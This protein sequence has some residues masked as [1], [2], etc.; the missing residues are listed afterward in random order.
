MCGI[1]G[2]V[3]KRP[4]GFYQGDATLFKNMLRINMIRG[5]DSTGVFGVGPKGNVDLVKGNSNGYVFTESSN[6]AEFEA[7]MRKKY[8]IVV[9][10]N[11]SATVGD[12]TPH[13]AHP[14][15]VGNI[16]LVHNGTLISTANL[17]KTTVDSE[18]IAHALNNHDMD[19]ALGKLHGAYALVWY[20]IAE[21]SLNIAR[22]VQRPLSILEYPDFWSIQSEAMMAAWLNGREQRKHSRIIDIEPEKVYSFTVGELG[23]DPQIQ[24]YKEYKPPYYGR[25]YPPEIPAQ[26][27]L[28]PPVTGGG[29]TRPIFGNSGSLSWRLGDTIRILFDDDKVTGNNRIFLGHPVIEDDIDTN[30]IVQYQLNNNDGGE[31]A[32]M[33]ELVNKGTF[34]MGKISATSIYHGRPILYVANV[35]PVFTIRALGGEEID[36]A[37]ID[38]V[39]ANGCPRCKGVVKREEIPETLIRQKVSGGVRVV[40]KSCLTESVKKAEEHRQAHVH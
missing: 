38:E 2:L 20:N 35:K 7:R 37:I 5:D 21:K 11:R 27:A 16:V 23:K 39:V 29:T 33:D 10:H 6:F 26:R 40:C 22:N 18:A 28:P 12:V 36:A 30:L 24:A 34:F 31:C 4:N 9:G 19:E 1:V 14:F 17:T 13:N 15:K 32:R 3:A 8:V 25:I